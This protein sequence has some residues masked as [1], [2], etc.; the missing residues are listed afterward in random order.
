MEHI[1]A[2][3]EI[4]KDVQIKESRLREFMQQQDLDAIIL[5]RQENFA[6]FTCGGDNRVIITSE[7]GFAY[8]VITATKKWIVAHSIDLQRFLEEQVAGQGYEAV[9]L[10]WYEGSPL[11]KA[12]ELVKGKSVGADVPA[13]GTR[14]LGSEIIALHTPFTDLEIQR[15]RWVGKTSHML[16]DQIAREIIP[17]MSELEIAAQIQ[18]AYTRHDM[19]LD[20]LIV[21]VDERI[22]RYRHPLPT[23]RGLERYALLH[24]A[25]RRWGLHANVT[26][27]VHFGQPPD[28]IRRA[29]DGVLTIEGRIMG[30]LSEGVRY[31]DILAAQKQWYA[32]VGFPEDWKYHFQG[33]TTGYGLADPTHSMNPAATVKNRI[34]FDYFVTITG[35][36]AE[37]LALLTD[38]GLEIVSWG[39]GWPMRSI[40]TSSGEIEVPD[41]L[42]R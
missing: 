10:F 23:G 5:N 13:P 26:R 21:G 24:P 18:E 38:G 37:N 19:T 14:F 35:A 4:L 25:A 27:L 20:V 15:L 11:E 34:A 33:G 7:S 30:M 28:E 12:L 40:Q 39:E 8:L 2:R 16:L 1:G 42:I 22:R 31:A 6:W 29:V 3:E 17:G 36:K 9:N 41:M 32:D